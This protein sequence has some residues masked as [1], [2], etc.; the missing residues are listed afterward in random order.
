MS[1]QQST[2]RR[3]AID[4][5]PTI[6]AD[7]HHAE[8]GIP[9]FQRPFIWE[10][11]KR[12]QL[13][14]SIK[15]G[16]PIGSLM[17]W[18]TT[19][20]V[21]T[22]PCIGP[23][24]VP[25]VDLPAGATRQYLLDGRQRLTTLYAALGRTFFE[26]EDRQPMASDLADVIDWFVYYDLEAEA[27]ELRRARKNLPKTWLPLHLLLD[28]FALSSWLEENIGIKSGRVLW[29]RAKALAAHFSDYLIPLIPI[30]SEDIEEVATTFKRVNDGGTQ[31]GDF[32]MV[33]ALT[34]SG[35]FDLGIRTAS[36]L[37]TL[38]QGG[39]G[40]L[41][42]D[43]VLKVIATEVKVSPFKFDAEQLAKKLKLDACAIDR[44]AEQLGWTFDFLDKQMDIRGPGV[45]PYT[46]QLLFVARGLRI[47]G[48]SPTTE[49]CDRIKAWVRKTSILS[50]LGGLGH[51]RLKPALADFECWVETGTPPKLTSAATAPECRHYNFGH[52]RTRILALMLAGLKPRRA[53]GTPFK[54][55][56]MDLARGGNDSTPMLLDRASPGLEDYDDDQLAALG[57]AIKSS[58][59]NRVIAPEGVADL[60]R[61]LIG[62]VPLVNGVAASHAITPEA[63][64]AL[65]RGDYRSFLMFRRKEIVR[66]EQQLLEGMS[67]T[68][69][70][71][72][73]V[74]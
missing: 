60:R 9:R 72:E 50:A 34:W 23:Y 31:M 49:Q 53:D 30:A 3:P 67:L 39:W 48:G 74:A 52:A 20:H 59:A 2:V 63:L 42:P 65:R 26:Q 57:S 29:N 55:P 73:P 44:V 12:L 41:D 13:L 58:P 35:D 27:F 4:R 7:L 5:L 22:D 14:D 51:D 1:K 10:D 33:H 71:Q 36:L 69:E 61:A 19:K 18:S 24:Q 8:Y 47:V 11:D 40:K 56:F 32:D 6:L 37:E 21:A 54:D 38:A 45:L 68:I 46:H 66:L 62:A 17:I 16:L 28:G 64:A 25:R 15:R 70:I 43:W